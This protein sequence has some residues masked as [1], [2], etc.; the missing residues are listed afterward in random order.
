MQSKNK[1]AMTAAERNHVDKVRA[2][3]CSVCDTP[4]PSEAH[5][6]EQ[7]LW[8]AS[9]A[10]CESCHRGPVNGWHGQRRIWAVKKMAELDAVAVTV[11]RLMEQRA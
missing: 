6:P 1:P 2:L 10:L 7:G 11:K 5:E 9:C 3:P 8:F 4:G